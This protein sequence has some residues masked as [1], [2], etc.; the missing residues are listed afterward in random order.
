LELN[1]EN[2]KYI[3]DKYKNLE[4]NPCITDLKLEI[5]TNFKIT[6][7]ED[8]NSKNFILDNFDKKY[9]HISANNE[10][11]ARALF[12]KN[13]PFFKILSVNVDYSSNALNT[14]NLYYKVP[15]CV[16]FINVVVNPA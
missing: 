14:F 10:T 7:T 5:E 13:N 4:L 8:A 9:C 1:I 15:I 6:Y 16:P 11:F 3:F 2:V 12:L